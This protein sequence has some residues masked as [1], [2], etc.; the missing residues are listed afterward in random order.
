MIRLIV[1]NEDHRAAL[2]RVTALAS[3]CERTDVESAELRVLALLVH[4]FETGARAELAAL[5]AESDDDDAVVAIEYALERMGL[6]R[7][8]LEPFLGSR[9]RVS[10]VLARKR[11]LSIE[12]IRKLHA[13]LHI[14]LHL[15]IR[16]TKKT[17]QARAKKTTTAARSPR[18][19]SKKTAAKAARAKP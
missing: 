9:S 5:L 15:L 2:D 12:M 19:S 13:G 3:K 16:E 17:A 14:P 18:A 10:E 8:D 11:G 6:A 1:S 4:D 7:K